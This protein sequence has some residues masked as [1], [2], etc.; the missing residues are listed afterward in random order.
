M[1]TLQHFRP[2]G[3]PLPTSKEEVFYRFSCLS[4]STLICLCDFDPIEIAIES[5]LEQ[6]SRSRKQI[7]PNPHEL[8]LEPYLETP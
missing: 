8:F 3:G 6:Y 7:T 5:G 4:T 2:V 1:S